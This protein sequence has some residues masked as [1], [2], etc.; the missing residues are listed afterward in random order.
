MRNR[1]CLIV[2]SLQMLETEHAA[3]EMSMHARRGGSLAVAVCS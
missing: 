3:A 1:A 2:L